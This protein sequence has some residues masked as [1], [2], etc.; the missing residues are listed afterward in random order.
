MVYRNR[1]FKDLL[2]DTVIVLIIILVLSIFIIVVSTVTLRALRKISCI[3][4]H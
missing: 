4:L 1:I 2:Y 3:T